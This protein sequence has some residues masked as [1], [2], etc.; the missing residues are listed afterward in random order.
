VS[1]LRVRRGV[2]GE[3]GYGAGGEK[4]VGFEQLPK[5]ATSPIE[6]GAL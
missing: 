5:M 3:D 6:L 2:L 4:R 1:K